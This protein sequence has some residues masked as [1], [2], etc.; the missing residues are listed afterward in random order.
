MQV[1]K[2]QV[3][4][5]SFLMTH[6]RTPREPRLART[7]QEGNAKK[8]QTSLQWFDGESDC[9]EQLQDQGSFWEL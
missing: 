8:E 3:I 2:K 7:H 5:R 9:K 1:K 6:L 4:L